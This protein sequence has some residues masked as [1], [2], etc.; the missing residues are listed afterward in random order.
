MADPLMSAGSAL[1]AL[2]QTRQLVQGG[3]NPLVAVRHG[4]RED[5]AVVYDKFLGLCVTFYRL[6]RDYLD[7]RDRGDDADALGDEIPLR[8][9]EL[10]SALHAIE[11]R[12]PKDVRD[13]ARHLFWRIVGMPA[14]EKSLYGSWQIEDLDDEDYALILLSNL[15]GFRPTSPWSSGSSLAE[16][17][18]KS[19]R[20]KRLPSWY[21]AWRTRR[22]KKKVTARCENRSSFWEQETFRHSAEFLDGVGHFAWVARVDVNGRWRWWHWPMALIP[23]LKRWQLER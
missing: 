19:E 20:R 21:R 4:R 10:Y 7:R 6:R 15:F 12:A 14:E 3:A 8:V 22:R 11:L 5:R 23:P 1:R 16:L 2:N 9:D 17:E 18:K 13:A